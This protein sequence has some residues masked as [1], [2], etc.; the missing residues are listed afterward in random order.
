LKVVFF[1]SYF[2]VC[3]SDQTA[4]NKLNVRRQTINLCFQ[5]RSNGEKIPEAD[6]RFFLGGDAPLR[7]VVADWSCKQN[8]EIPASYNMQVVFQVLDWF[9]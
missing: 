1:S 5:I 3:V 8:D 7:N 9:W 6:P 4:V 2:C